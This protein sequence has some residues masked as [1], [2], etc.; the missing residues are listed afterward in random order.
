MRT[1]LLL[2]ALFVSSALALTNGT[3][4]MTTGT[5][6]RVSSTSQKCTGYLIQAASTN[7]AVI[8]FGPSTVTSSNG[9]KLV[10]G[11]S[12]SW[13]PSGTSF[14]YDMNQ[15]YL[16]GTTGDSAVYSCQ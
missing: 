11:A 9:I 8:Y 3:V 10:A 13:F 7:A 14:I 5:A 1:I 15:I 6:V 4:A 2:L 16:L 12:I